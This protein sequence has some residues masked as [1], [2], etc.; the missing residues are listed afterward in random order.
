M[1]VFFS[2]ACRILLDLWTFSPVRARAVL[3]KFSAPRARTKC[4]QYS[5]VQ[6]ITA[7]TMHVLAPVDGVILLAEEAVMECEQKRKPAIALAGRFVRRGGCGCAT[8]EG[9]CDQ[10]ELVLGLRKVELPNL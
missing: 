4:A 5:T 3:E 1:H 6:Y 2:S 9:T 8:C 7:R 10:E